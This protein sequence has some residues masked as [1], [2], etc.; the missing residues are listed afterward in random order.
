M[1][2]SFGMRRKG[3]PGMT[4]SHV[5]IRVPDRGSPSMIALINTREIVLLF[6]GGGGGEGGGKGDN[7]REGGVGGIP[8]HIFFGVF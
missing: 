6:R 1:Q 5:L 7:V 8:Q 2:E 4:K 3:R